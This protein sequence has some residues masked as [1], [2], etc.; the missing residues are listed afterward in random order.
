MKN[1]AD[2]SDLCKS[3]VV[4]KVM[5]IF[6][7]L[8]PRPFALNLKQPEKV[9]DEEAFSKQKGVGLTDEKTKEENEKDDSL[10]E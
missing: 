10:D 9:S 4:T 1:V 3:F 8:G 5:D 6:P 2:L 7:K